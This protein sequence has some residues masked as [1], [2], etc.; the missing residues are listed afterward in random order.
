[1]ERIRNVELEPG[2]VKAYAETFISRWDMYPIQ[3]QGGYVTVK[4]PLRSGMV[5]SH[6]LSHWRGNKPLTLGAY[7]L[8]PDSTAKWLCLDADDWREWE[9]IWRL[10][11]NLKGQ[12]V[13]TYAETSR[14]GGHLWLF[15]QSPIAGKE[16]RTF[17]KYLANAFDLPDLEIYPKQDQLGDG[18]GS[19]VRLPLGVHQK[20]GKVHHFVGLDGRPLAPRINQQI[21]LLA[22]PDRVPQSFVEDV[23]W[24][25]YLDKRRHE[26]EAE[27]LEL[28]PDFPEMSA[29]ETL[30]ESI[31]NS[32]TVYDLVSQ[33]ADLDE[34]GRGHCPFH[35]DKHKSFGVNRQKNY[36]HCWAGCG[37]G[38]VI[39]FMM[40][41]RQQNG[42]D[43]S[44]T[45]T[46]S[47]M[48]EMFLK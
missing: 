14:R 36:W 12:G 28:I 44:F 31:K 32:I 38:S 2:I 15:F 1:M 9:E 26:S 30:S 46:I 8:S 35:E 37:G 13:P 18:P 5:F 17:G 23:L 41:L 11:Q 34:R 24:K 27:D 19:L 10:A 47:A 7:A 16:A 22:D 21:E 29:G 40:R 45:A 20:S 39:D 43:D 25:D 4:K 48:R 3:V 33:Y 6:I 42:E